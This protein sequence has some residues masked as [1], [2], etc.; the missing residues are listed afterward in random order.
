M[1][2]LKYIEGQTEL[3]KEGRGISLLS[4]HHTVHSKLVVER[5]PGIVTFERKD[6]KNSSRGQK[7]TSELGEKRLKHE[8]GELA[9][10]D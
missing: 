10:K 9:S 3:L 2:G 1:R 5:R 4:G 7:E 6:S 8:E